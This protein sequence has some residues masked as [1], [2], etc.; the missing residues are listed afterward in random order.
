MVDIDSLNDPKSLIFAEE[1]GRREENDNDDERTV[2]IEDRDITQSTQFVPRTDNDESPIR[3]FPVKGRGTLETLIIMGSSD[4]YILNVSVDNSDIVDGQSYS[5]LNSISPTLSHIDAYTDG[6]EFIV[7]INRY[8]FKER[9]RA[10]I[11]PNGETT[12][13]LVRAELMMK[14]IKGMNTEE[15]KFIET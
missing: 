7:T 8:P 10:T 6:T 1:F 15:S 13:S 5:E 4:D 9:L 11:I 12:F 2:I 14:E 3:D